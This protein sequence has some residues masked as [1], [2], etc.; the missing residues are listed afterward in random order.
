[1]SPSRYT[2]SVSISPEGVQVH[3]SG[4]EGLFRKKQIERTMN[5]AWNEV[6][7]VSAF[8][9]DCFACD[10]ICL[11]FGLN[12]THTTEISEE[13]VGDSLIAALPTYL[14]GALSA[15]EWWGEVVL[16]PFE[17]CWTELYKRPAVQHSPSAQEP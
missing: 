1:M 11:E 3:L 15:S 4:T 13:A 5:F 17:L 7:H 6:T 10:M 12:G 14:P 16:P 9:R 2:V 8:K